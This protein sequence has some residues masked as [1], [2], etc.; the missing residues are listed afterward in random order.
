MNIPYKFTFTLVLLL[1][2][3]LS[4][5]L[6]KRFFFFR[7][8][9]YKRSQYFTKLTTYFLLCAFLCASGSYKN[10]DIQLPFRMTQPLSAVSFFYFWVAVLSFFHNYFLL[11]TLHF[12]IKSIIK[13]VVVVV[14]TFAASHYEKVET[15]ALRLNRASNMVEDYTVYAKQNEPVRCREFWLKLQIKYYS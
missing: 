4:E 9:S 7:F 11:R 15:Q 6:L 13:I 1:S 12:C 2:V 3:I 8:F 14:V 5:K 10:F